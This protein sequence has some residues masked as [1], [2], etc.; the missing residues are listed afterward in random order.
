MN[1]ILKKQLN[2]LL[3]EN[4]EVNL[5]ISKYARELTGELTH[6]MFNNF[7]SKQSMDFVFY[8]TQVKIPE[9]F[10]HKLTYKK[11][12]HFVKTQKIVIRFISRNSKMKNQRAFL[13]YASDTNAII[14]LVYDDNGVQYFD[15]ILTGSVD[16]GFFNFFEKNISKV[17]Y[18]SILHELQ[19]LYD[20]WLSGGNAFNKQKGDKYKTNQKNAYDLSQKDMTVKSMNIIKN[21]KQDYFRLPHEVNARY[22]TA[23]N[24][25][26]FTISDGDYIK[27][28]DFD[29]VLWDFKTEYFQHYKELTKVQQKRVTQ[30]LYLAYD[31]K[32]EKVTKFNLN[33]KRMYINSK[34]K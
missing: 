33:L 30:R 1:I 11:I 23:I 6:N 10:T 29:D 28:K 4:Y 8:K 5:D 3:V 20:A 2:T 17:F 14:N 12:N 26:Q 9:T 7:N 31:Y 24:Q 19:H 34:N 13:S 27:M 32:K 16:E 25:I 22:A 21:A 18:N 15:N